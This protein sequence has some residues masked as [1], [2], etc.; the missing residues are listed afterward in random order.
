MVSSGAGGEV[1]FI[2]AECGVSELIG[3]LYLLFSLFD[4]SICPL[5]S[6]LLL[7]VV[8][9]LPFAAS[10]AGR[11]FRC[12]GCSGARALS[13]E[14]GMIPRNVMVLFAKRSLLARSSHHVPGPTAEIAK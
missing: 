4:P 3:H 9:S 10:P 5:L 7:Q 1:V 6:F 14:R 11:H 8:F 12:C 13:L 2:L